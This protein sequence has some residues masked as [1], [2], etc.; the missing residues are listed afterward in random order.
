MKLSGVKLTS[1][2]QTGRKM[3]SIVKR[4]AHD[5]GCLSY[6]P[7]L[8]YFYYV[9]SIP[10]QKDPIAIEFIQ[11]PK[12]SLNSSPFCDC[13]DK[14]I[15]MASWAYLNHIP[16]RIVAVGKQ[17]LSHVFSE[18]FLEGEWIPLDATYPHSEPAV[19]KQWPIRKIL[20]VL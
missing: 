8:D 5:I 11:R 16:C 20:G 3:I 19:F 14:T 15:L 6:L 10:Y 17:R 1:V 12:Y 4:F 18:F 9:A 7:L 2:E 13:D